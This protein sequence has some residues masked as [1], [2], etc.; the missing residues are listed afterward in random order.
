MRIRRKM[1]IL[2]VVNISTAKQIAFPIFIVLLIVQGVRFFNSG[3][4]C[5]RL[6]DGGFFV[7]DDIWQADGCMLHRYSVSEKQKC[8]QAQKVSFVGD[9]RMRE[10]FYVFVDALSDETP[11]GKK[12]SDIYFK[13][14]DMNVDFLWYPEANL[15]TVALYDSWIKDPSLQPD[16][17]IHSVATHTIKRTNGDSSALE[18]YKTNLTK[19]VPQ[20]QKIVSQKVSNVYWVLQDPVYEEK[21]HESRQSITNAIV[22]QYN[23]V[24][25]SIFQG[26]NGFNKYPHVSVLKSTVDVAVQN[27]KSSI[28]GLH[29]DI[30]TQTIDVHILNNLICNEVLKPVDGSCCQKP[31]PASIVQI[32][33]FVFGCLSIVAAVI[34]SILYN[35][36]SCGND[37]VELGNKEGDSNVSP[38][39][40][41]KEFTTACAKMFI[42]LFYFYLCDRTDVFMKSNKHYT[43]ARFFIPL[44]YVVFLGIFGIDQCKSSSFLNRDQTDEWKGWMQLVILI[45]HITGASSNLPIYMHIRLLVSMY[46][47]MTGYGHFSY[48][49]NKGDFSFY[50]VFGVMFRLNFLTVMLCLMMNRSYQ[51]YYFVPLCSFWFLVLYVAMSMWPRAYVIPSKPSSKPDGVT[52]L[53]E[54]LQNGPS[55][56]SPIVMMSFKLI[57]LTTIIIVVFL[58]QKTFEALFSWWPVI[59]LFELPPG[60]VREW[61]FRCHLDQFAMLHGALFCFAYLLLK[62]MSFLDDSKQGCLMSMK[63]SLITVT[64]SIGILMCYSYWTLQCTSKVDCNHI[65]TYASILPIASFILIR[66]IP[67]YLRSGYSSFFAWFGK[68]SLEL[69]VGQYHIWLAADT[70]G[71]LVLTSPS[72]P[73]LNLVITTFIFVCTAHEI[74]VLTNVFVKY[75]VGSPTDGTKVTCFRFIIISMALVFFA[76]ISDISHD[77]NH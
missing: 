25:L 4:A 70:K 50:R 17:I 39:G 11:Q 14:N 47:F 49:W 16:I 40:I 33:M 57:V 1:N 51:F 8:L 56:R 60:S 34:S 38:M 9:S 46:L 68:I 44:L 64:I 65:H 73:M 48:F 66:N 13:E 76:M 67:G 15:S 20:M 37:N 71:V 42:I 54:L 45:Y 74:G 22:S 28:D 19:L 63:A 21:L 18:E 2:K 24:A 61:W 29:M 52:E 59:R 69:F 53:E 6:L 75:L 10:L 43:N 23:D 31:P 12:H 30:N 58:S 26:N 35:I 41:F 3:D 7:N 62:R 77:N 36:E 55:R 27:I 5:H 32:I 72:W